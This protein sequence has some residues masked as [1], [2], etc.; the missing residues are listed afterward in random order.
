MTDDDIKDRVKKLDDAIKK[1]VAN[2]SRLE[3]FHPYFEKHDPKSV[4][5]LDDDID[6]VQTVIDNLKFARTQLYPEKTQTPRP[7]MSNEAKQFT[8][9]FT[10]DTI[11]VKAEKQI[12]KADTVKVSTEVLKNL[13]DRLTGIEKNT[14]HSKRNLIVV[15]II[16]FLAGIGSTLMMQYINS[17]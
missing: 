4:K 2:K 10:I 9:S 5:K 11:L 17:L 7:S 3:S 15:F 6:N 14:S 12:E 1:Y 13:A 16:S 8:D